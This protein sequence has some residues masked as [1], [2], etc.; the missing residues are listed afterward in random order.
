MRFL[1]YLTLFPLFIYSQQSMNSE[2]KKNLLKYSYD[3]GAKIYTGNLFLD[4]NKFSREGIYFN[5]NVFSKKLITKKTNFIKQV[6]FNLNNAFFKKINISEDFGDMEI[7]SYSTRIPNILSCDINFTIGFQK[8]INSFFSHSF[9]L[10]FRAWPLFYKKGAIFGEESNSL[11]GLISSE[12]NGSFPGLNK[13][14]KIL[15]S[16]NYLY[17]QSKELKLLF[18]LNSDF[19]INTINSGRVY[20][21][22][23]IQFDQALNFN[24][25]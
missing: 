9:C 25:K 10:K 21:G 1:I 6:S 15:Y 24:R 7:S 2:V 3:F 14:T 13:T 16:I 17:N 19:G 4:Q 18:F 8:K 23:G 5:L 12:E 22:F 11:G 20:P